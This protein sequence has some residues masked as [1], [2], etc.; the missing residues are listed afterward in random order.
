MMEKRKLERGVSEGW[1]CLN[2]I[3]LPPLLRMG[4]STV[5]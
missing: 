2:I 1:K 4:V 3:I 5:Q